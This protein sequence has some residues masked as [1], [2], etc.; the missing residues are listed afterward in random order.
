M[1]GGLISRQGHGIEA[2]VEGE[3]S[4]DFL[5]ARLRRRIIAIGLR[6]ARVLNSRS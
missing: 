2:G 3:V 5:R 6:D 4:N 1:S